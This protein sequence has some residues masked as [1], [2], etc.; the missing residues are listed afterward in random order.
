MSHTKSK[1]NYNQI[2]E[3]INNKRRGLLVEQLYS[4]LPEDNKPSRKYFIDFLR[5]IPGVYV[6]K[7][8]E[9]MNRYFVT[10]LHGTEF[11]KRKLLVMLAEWENK[12]QKNVSWYKSIYEIDEVYLEL[13]KDCKFNTNI[14]KT[15]SVNL[16]DALQMVSSY[17]GNQKSIFDRRHKVKETVD[18]A[19]CQNISEKDEVKRIEIDKNSIWCNPFKTSEGWEKWEV[20]ELYIAHFL[21]NNLF[22]RIKELSNKKIVISNSEEKHHLKFLADKTKEFVLGKDKL[23]IIKFQN[24][25]IDLVKLYRKRVFLEIIKNKNSEIYGLNFHV[26][27][28]DDDLTMKKMTKLTSE[29]TG[30]IALHNLTYPFKINVYCWNDRKSQLYKN[31]FTITSKSISNISSTKNLRVTEYYDSLFKGFNFISLELDRYLEQ[32]GKHYWSKPE[33]RGFLS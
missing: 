16:I 18:N 10:T 24:I 8:D 20:E 29:I 28:V 5:S 17:I 9:R 21:K 27:D 4:L 6:C 22:S 3:I 7:Y 30:F 2:I 25:N 13:I 12:Y 19:Y 33:N 32:K 14:Q 23:D 31:R 26:L 1:Y 11:S 15:Y